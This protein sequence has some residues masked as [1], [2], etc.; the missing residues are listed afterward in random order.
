ME[1]RGQK[2]ARPVVDGK[3]FRL[4]EAKFCVKG[5][6]YGPFAPNSREEAFAEP[7]PTGQDFAQIASLGANVVRVYYVPPRWV[8][9]LA[10]RF[11]LKLWV[12]IPWPKH[13]C[14][15]ESEDLRHAA[16]QAVRQAVLSGRGHPAVFA[17]SV[18]N[19]I[20]SE[21]VR[22]SGPRRIEAFIEELVEEAK[23]A[24]PEC[25]C[26]FANF[27]PTEF[28][29][30]ANLDFVSFN[31]YLHE[32]R[33]FES[34]LGRL[35]MLADSK[36][37]VLAEFGLDSRR[38][39]E[40]RQAEFVAWQI[41]LAFRSGLAGVVAFS[42][43]DDWFRGG[44]PITDWAFGL[45]TRQRQPKPAFAAVQRA[46]RAAP[47]FPLPRTPKVS[48]VVA[49][50]NGARTL[51]TCLESLSKLNY[52]DYE[53][54]LVDDGSTDATQ[55]MARR[56]PQVHLLT[57]PTNR[58]LSA[59]RNTGIAAATGEW[60]AFTDSD[61]RA[62][63]DWLY[64][65]VTDLLRGDF[66]GIGGHNLLP[67]ED[68]AVAAAVMVSPGGPAHVMLTDSEAEHIPGCNMLFVKRAFE[69]V[70]GFDPMFHKAGDDVDL[71]WR[72]QQH[73]FKI[74]FSPA[75]F[76]WHYRRSTVGAYLRQQR[77]YGEAE[78]MLAQKHPEYFNPLG[79]S[80]WRGRIYGPS[81]FGVILE[82]SVIYHG[83]FGGGFFQKLYA[84]HPSAAVMFCTS[85]E[86]HV[87]I[88]APL[89]AVS[90][91][92]APF[93]PVA[94]ASLLISLSVCVLAGAQA[95]LPRAQRRFWSRPLV[96][97]LFFLQPIARGLARYQ[98]SLTA[99]SFSSP[100]KRAPGS[101]KPALGR[102]P[103]QTL[104][105]WGQSSVDR[106]AF[107]RASLLRLQAE[108]WQVRPDTGWNEFDFEV[109]GNRW[110]RLRVTTAAEELDQGK[111]TLRCRFEPRWSLLAKVLFWFLL[112]M[113]LVTI[114]QV[115]AEQ[116][117]IWFLLLTM[118]VAF[119]MLEHQQ[120]VL[121]EAVMILVDQTALAL[122]LTP[123]QGD[124]RRRR[125]KP[126][127]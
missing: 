65:L 120:W 12:D 105:Y 96:A 64:Y 47:N 31:V 56:F 10:E 33:A 85:I 112:G 89:W 125:V 74:G 1:A 95:N 35:Q 36:P 90:A 121:R 59:A 16:R 24:D 98:A 93:W 8:L 75:G 45:T 110:S 32:P 68:S 13:L 67:A 18:V 114:G 83:V 29:H 21:I 41:E 23:A 97:M 70:G 6:T 30:P 99:R 80:I 82:R 101:A 7:E 44:R 107:L 20:P 61:C 122:E 22:W 52:P 72:L 86:F 94:L 60:V 126:K 87:L 116:P 117:W 63:E 102:E 46:F 38:E 78:A 79:L 9:D 119:W 49:S 81:K 15:L 104:A 118:P 106:F 19:E 34:Y 111:R 14:F 39:G 28:L 26:T 58:G 37:L 91:A 40:A 124:R 54:I 25:L 127:P 103:V 50:Y 113:E 123:L 62:D 76:V 5:V 73:G 42:F 17:Y 43:T 57:H 66:I 48:V 77:G 92:F 4:G 2:T 3:F 71:C 84:P 27:P 115:A 108:G 69:V 51:A 11:H 55:E 53:V 109:L 88:T 100:L